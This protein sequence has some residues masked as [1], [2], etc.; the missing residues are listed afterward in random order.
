A[1]ADS[2]V[3]ADRLAFHRILPGHEDEL[4]AVEVEPDGGDV[5]PPVRSHSGQLRSPRL[6]GEKA[7][8]F[9]VGHPRHVRLTWSDE[10]AARWREYSMLVEGA[11]N[12]VY[13]ELEIRGDLAQ[14][15]ASA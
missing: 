4:V 11:K 8:P 3:A 14:S 2:P 13:G 12:V 7:P 9:G 15:D 6:A 10:A 1:E 5:R